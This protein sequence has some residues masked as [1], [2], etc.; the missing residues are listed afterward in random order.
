MVTGSGG[1]HAHSRARAHPRRM[2]PLLSYPSTRHR[3]VHPCAHTH[4][5]TSPGAPC[6][7]LP[8]W[9]TPST[10]HR[11]PAHSPSPITPTQELT[12]TLTLKTVC[13]PP[14]TQVQKFH[15]RQ[16]GSTH[17]WHTH[18]Q[19]H[20]LIHFLTQALAREIEHTHTTRSPALLHR[21]APSLCAQPGILP[22]QLH[23]CTPNQ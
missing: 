19:T 16:L 17:N 8:S 13:T 4:W 2:P 7:P 21:R 22:C 15:A 9:L 11:V 12:L 1:G 20:I 23:P 18:T 10:A 5:C 6:L 14:Q 3:L